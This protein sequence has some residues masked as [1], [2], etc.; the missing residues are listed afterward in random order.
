MTTPTFDHLSAA[1]DCGRLHL[2]NRITAAP[3]FTGLEFNASLAELTRFYAR[4]ADDGVSMVTVCAGLVHNSGAP[5]RNW[6]AF[7]EELDVPRHRQLTGLLREKGCKAV[8]QLEH[9]GPAARSWPRW[10][11]SSIR[12]RERASCW[13]MPNFL[14]RRIIDSFIKTARLAQQS[15][16]DGVEIHAAD[17]SLAA[18]FLSPAINHRRDAWG[19]TQLARFKFVLD[20]VRGIRKAA[21]EDFIIGVHFN[22]VELSPHGAD[23]AEMLRFTQMLRIAGTDYLR[24]EFGG[25]ENRIPT[26]L[27]PIPKNVWLPE[28]R[29]LAENTTLAVIYNADRGRIEDAD[30]ALEGSANMVCAL[31]RQLVADE[32]FI[33]KS[34]TMG[35]ETIRPWIEH[36]ECA[37]T[38]D[39]SREHLLFSLSSPFSFNAFPRVFVPAEKKRTI[40][41]IGG[42]LS[43]MLFAVVAARRG[44]CVRLF[45]EHDFLG[46]SL[47]FVGKI[48][49]SS[50]IRTLIDQLQNE[51]TSLGVE[52]NLKAKERISNLLSLKDTELFI[53]STG[54]D[55]EIPDFPGIDSSNVVTYEELLGE[56]APVGNRVAVLGVNPISVN[57]CRYLLEQ[58][59]ESEL[60]AE[61]WRSAWG[62]GD[63]RSHKGGVLGVVPE[64]EPPLRQVYLVETERGQIQRLLQDTPSRWELQ[65][66]LM[67]GAQ[68]LRDVN[69]ESIDNFSLRASWGDRHENRYAVRVDHVVVCCGAV[70]NT[71]LAA[72]LSIAGRNVL[73]LG[74]AAAESGYISIYDAAHEA[75]EKALEI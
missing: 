52:I 2:K 61:Q 65:W 13:R 53:I 50:K 11:S 4:L 55:P 16:Y 71:D 18:A 10:S 63:F 72:R 45:E 1:L 64:I 19:A 36:P 3:I 17:H 62:I 9:A 39:L 29:L 23:W 59:E 40:A 15:G 12:Q 68:T 47:Y 22:L 27:H 69:I 54:S 30:A 73:T 48:R 14:I 51:L 26:Y 24:P 60:T 66:L 58:R 7:D 44:H 46:G 37:R 41:V 32:H 25:F 5:G 43:G 42:G 28:C 35:Q 31:S 20:I 70:P 57:V 21:G 75:I 38:D 56:N 67:R 34:L 6:R 49:Q 74:A 33:R 8:L